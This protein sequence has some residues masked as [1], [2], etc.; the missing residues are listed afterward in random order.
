MTH[1]RFK[2]ILS[3]SVLAGLLLITF[4]LEKIYFFEYPSCLIIY[5]IRLYGVTV[6]S[7]K[8]ETHLSSYLKKNEVKIR[9][10]QSMI[11][12][13][14]KKTISLF[15]YERKMGGVG[16]DVLKFN[17]V[18]SRQIPEIKKE[19]ACYILDLLQKN[20]TIEFQREVWNL[21]YGK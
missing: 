3:F 7:Q 14:S 13:V 4:K 9:S 2:Y 11:F 17:E 6:F 1:F 16:G 10:L 5:E 18:I 21:F 12:L 8:R 15:G 20:N 19:D